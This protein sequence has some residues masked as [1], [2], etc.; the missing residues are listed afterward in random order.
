MQLINNFYSPFENMI[1]SYD[2]CFLCGKKLKR[3][4]VE[5]VFPKWLMNDFDL[6]DQKITLLNQ[7]K[8]NYRQLIIPCCKECNNVYLSKVEKK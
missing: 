2:R 6:W 3:K 7:T 5:H 4:T 1:F 8:I